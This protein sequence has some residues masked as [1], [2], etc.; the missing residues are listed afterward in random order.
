M[1]EDLGH[2]EAHLV[3]RQVTTNAVPGAEAERPMHI[4]PIIVEWR[5]WVCCC[6][7]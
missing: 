3:I 1:E 5:A 4:P 6:L 7:G 2:D